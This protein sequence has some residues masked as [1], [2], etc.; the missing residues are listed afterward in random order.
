M[1]A[2]AL[3]G[4]IGCGKST[5]AALLATYPDVTI[6]DC[7]EIAKD[8][9]KS[10]MFMP[11]INRIVGENVFPGGKADLK[12]IGEIIFADSQK[13]AAFEALIHPHVQKAVRERVGSAQSSQVT[14]G[15]KKICIVE[16]AIIYEIGWQ[17]EFVAVIV[18]S[19]SK[20]EQFH[21][22]LENRHMTREQI[23]ARMS[24]QFSTS[25]KEERAQFVIHTDCDID[26]LARRASDLY[27]QVKEYKGGK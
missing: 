14:Q 22:L 23:T 15:T 26:E 1:N 5:V 24:Q 8:I 25:H 17:S 2:Y 21:R 13:K 18:V 9:I 27:R 11:L 10:G 12:R 6:I 16:A 7:D 3:T 19:C 20:D 4:N